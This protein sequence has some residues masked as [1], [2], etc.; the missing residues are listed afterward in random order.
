MATMSLQILSELR[1]SLGI[2]ARC[3][4]EQT[5]DLKVHEQGDVVMG[6]PAAGFIHTD[7]WTSAIFTV[8]RASDT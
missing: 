6:A 1:E 2:F 5:L 4:E 3:G 8:V 7:A